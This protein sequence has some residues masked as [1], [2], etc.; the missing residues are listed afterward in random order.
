MKVKAKFLGAHPRDVEAAT[1]G[2]CFYA[3]DL[4][5]GRL[6]F[7]VNKEVVTSAFL[8][9]EGDEVFI[10]PAILGFGPQGCSFNGMGEVFPPS[11]EEI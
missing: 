2:D 6:V 3:L 5:P 10:S 9:K 7:R 1:A 8:L 11:G 4:R